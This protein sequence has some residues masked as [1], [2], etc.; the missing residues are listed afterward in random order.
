MGLGLAICKHLVG[1]INAE[2]ADPGCG[3]MIKVK[4]RIIDSK[5]D[6]SAERPTKRAFKKEE[7]TLS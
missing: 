3:A 5:S 6:P 7:W 4:L 2:S 1:S